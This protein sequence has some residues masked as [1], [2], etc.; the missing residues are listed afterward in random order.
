MVVQVKHVIGDQELH[1]VRELL[2]CAEFQD[3][4]LSAG[5]A[6][7]QVKNNEEVCS[8]Q[9]VS[10]LNRIVMG[11]LVRHPEYKIAALPHRIAVPFYVRYGQGMAY[12]EHMDD[13]VMGEENRYRS[14]IAVTVF[15]NSPDE[16]EG[17]ELVIYTPF[18]HQSIKGSAGDAVLYPASTRHQVTPVT[19]GER[20][21]AVTWVQSLVRSYEQ[22][23][24]LYQ[25]GKTREK[26]LRKAP[27]SEDS[28]CIDNVYL[29]LVRMWSEI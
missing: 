29:N 4:R 27:D 13:P 23:D 10:E 26:M 9:T 5:L 22:R 11:N 20:L 18:G 7:Q 25:L 8:E 14:D 3:G 21:V 1:R 2:A 28:R 16:Y 15:L 24:L 19:R 17:G 6:A 12:G